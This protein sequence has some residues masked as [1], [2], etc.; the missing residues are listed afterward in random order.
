MQIREIRRA[1]D[2][3]VVDD[4]LVVVDVQEAVEVRAEVPDNRLWYELSSKR[5]WFESQLALNRKIP[6]HILYDSPLQEKTYQTL[7]IWCFQNII[8]TTHELHEVYE[9]LD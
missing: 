6:F 1:V 8:I 3:V 9:W 2:P 4:P 7:C 5:Q